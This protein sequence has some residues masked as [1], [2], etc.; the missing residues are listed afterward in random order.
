MPLLTVPTGIVAF[1]LPQGA[2][3][4][5]RPGPASGWIEVGPDRPVFY[6]LIVLDLSGA[7]GDEV[8]ARALHQ[9]LDEGE[10]I[11][12]VPTDRGDLFQDVMA[13][14][15]R[16]GLLERE[17]RYFLRMDRLPTGVVRILK[18]APGRADGESKADRAAMDALG[19]DVAAAARF[20]SGP[21]AL[22][23]TAGKPGSIMLNLRGRL[24]CPLPPGWAAHLPGE[25]D[26]DW[27]G[28]DEAGDPGAVVCL[29]PDE[30]ASMFVSVT[31]YRS[32]APLSPTEFAEA[33]D[34]WRAEDVAAVQSAPGMGRTVEVTDLE[35]ARYV[36]HGAFDPAELGYAGRHYHF[37]AASPVSMAVATFSPLVTDQAMA[38]DAASALLDELDRHVKRALLFVDGAE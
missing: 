25:I 3:F 20:A 37:R 11:A 28:D 29:A 31:A 21:T 23:R 4:G 24:F 15:V 6:D 10:T 16:R 13:I 8:A 26:P 34:G 36:V 27:E 19:L 9:A 5:K 14:E 17:G 22:D 1:D 18:V 2:V 12:E 32:D 30:T 38:P 35:P 7:P 33:L